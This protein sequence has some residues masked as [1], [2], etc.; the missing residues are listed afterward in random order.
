M[1]RLRV[2][3]IGA[4]NGMVGSEL[5]GSGA[6]MYVGIDII[7]ET[8]TATERDQPSSITTIDDLRETAGGLKIGS[9]I[10]FI[11]RSEWGA[12]R[13]AYELVFNQLLPMNPTLMYRAVRAGE[14]DVITALTGDGRIV[15]FDLRLLS[16]PRGAFP[17]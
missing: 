12:V 2:L 14:V 9:G 13:D 11:E 7:E 10:D 8:R 3:D 4:G 15:K 6:Q 1:G 16:D 17:P 5:M